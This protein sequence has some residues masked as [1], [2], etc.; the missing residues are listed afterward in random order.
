M[1]VDCLITNLPMC[2]NSKT[3]NFVRNRLRKLSE[4]C[5]GKIK[6]NH[7]KWAVIR[8]PNYEAAL[9]YEIYSDAMS[10]ALRAPT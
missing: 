3:Q 7:G 9:R 5:G 8:F 2:N 4:N 10:I 6:W 1:Q